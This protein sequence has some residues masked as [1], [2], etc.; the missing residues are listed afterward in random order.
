MFRGMSSIVITAR[1]AACAIVGATC[2]ITCT[3]AAPQVT[4][5]S[6]VVKVPAAVYEQVLPPA[7]MEMAVPGAALVTSGT[8]AGSDARA[9]SNSTNVG[10]S[11]GQ[12]LLE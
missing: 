12:E 1:C 9:P 8:V 2:G 4:L 3:G 6:V 11:T 10:A 5:V 7:E